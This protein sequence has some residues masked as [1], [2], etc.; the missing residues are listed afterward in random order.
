MAFYGVDDGLEMFQPGWDV[1]KQELFLDG[2]A[3]QKH[4]IDSES[5]QHPVLGRV[6]A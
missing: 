3:V 4:A 5:P 1:F 6:I 2:E